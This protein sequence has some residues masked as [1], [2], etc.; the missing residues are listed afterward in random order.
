MYECKCHLMLRYLPSNKRMDFAPV[1]LYP[2]S[3]WSLTK[4]LGA[5]KGFV[6]LGLQGLHDAAPASLIRLF[7]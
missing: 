7:L 3:A 2:E 6:T 1:P 5:S 4:D